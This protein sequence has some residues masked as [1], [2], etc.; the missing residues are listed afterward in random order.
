MQIKI[1]IKKTPEQNAAHYFELAKKFRKKA[2]GAE[3]A[4]QISFKKL[5]ELKKEKEGYD[6]KIEKKQEELQKKISERKPKK[7]FHKFRWFYSSEDFL[8][9]AGRDATTNEILIKKHTDKDD[10]VLHTALPGSPF[11]VIKA[12][13]KTEKSEVKQPGDE[14]MNEAA[15][16]C[17]AFSRAWRLGFLTLDVFYVK[18]E[19][20]SK[21]AQSGEFMGKGSFMIY[22]KKNFLHPSINLAVGVVDDGVMIAPLS[23]IKKHCR[24]FVEILPGNEKTS[25]VAKQIKKMIGGDFVVD[26]DEIISVLPGGGVKV[27]K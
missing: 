10:I 19:Q 2:E 25:D 9:V 3:K 6:K 16:F 23:A 1:D 15:S 5:D 20:V 21:T 22:G 4:L 18:P 14:T 27:K 12:K 26:L 7:W 17:A 13:G 24:K 8:V 11:V